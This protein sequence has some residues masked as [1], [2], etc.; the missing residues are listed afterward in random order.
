MP[1]KEVAIRKHQQVAQF[2]RTMLI[3][4]SISSIITAATLVTTGFLI[5]RLTF[6]SKVISARIKSIDNLKSNKNSLEDLVKKIKVLNTDELLINQKSYETEQPIMVIS[7]ALPINANSV[8]LSSS[9]YKKILNIQGIKID[10]MSSDLT[11]DEV[12]DQFG[13]SSSS[14]KTEYDDVKS[15]T[16]YFNFKVNGSANNLTTVL[17]NL[18]R[19]MRPFFVDNVDFRAGENDNNTMTISGRSFYT[20]K[21]QPQIQEIIMKDK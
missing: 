12:D 4:L 19:S 20:N 18:E 14:Y 6:N 2:R 11:S 8:A 15:P 9:L 16:I 1:K 21:V 13:S 10:S 17:K 7:D 5:K 3:I